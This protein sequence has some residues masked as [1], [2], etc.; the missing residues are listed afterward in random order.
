MNLKS[1]WENIYTSK[2]EDQM[3]WY[4]EYPAI[5]LK[6]FEEKN[7]EKDAA[8]IDI[9]GGQSR[10]AEVLIDKGF[11]NVTVL[12]ISASAIEN[13]RKRMGKKSEKIKWVVSD[14]N[15]FSPDEKYTFWHDRAVLHFLTTDDQVKDYLHRADLFIDEKGFL[16]LGTFSD[17]GPTKCSGLEIRQYT[18]DTITN[19]FGS[20]FEKLYCE[21]IN[22]L[23][24]AKKEQNF[25]FC[26]FRHK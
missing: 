9:G 26:N 3:S 4:E 17:K 5:S 13:N 7:L 2:T 19:L 10:F 25:V 22:H 12:D 23:T 16:T 18:E 15:S 6:Y 8:I 24:P 1:H 20:A 11:T 14:I 21:E